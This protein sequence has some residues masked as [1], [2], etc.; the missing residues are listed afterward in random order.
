ML[1]EAMNLA[2]QGKL[3]E[4]EKLV[5]AASAGGASKR[6][7]AATKSYID[8]FK[9]QQPASPQAGTS[10]WENNNQAQP[11]PIVAVAA[12]PPVVVV[13]APAPAPAHAP[14][15]YINPN[16]ALAKTTWETQI[17]MAKGNVT[18]EMMAEFV[19]CAVSN[20]NLHS[21]MPL[22]PTHV[23]LKRTCA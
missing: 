4:A 8:S 1:E 18:P 11:P 15:P 7:V 3:A 22:D 9:P 12:A 5:V 21:G 14:T 10:Y 13:A 17:K 2:E 6:N 20:R 23:R 19:R 16:L